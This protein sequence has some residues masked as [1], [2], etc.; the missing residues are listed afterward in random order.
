MSSVAHNM[1]TPRQVERKKRRPSYKSVDSVTPRGTLETQTQPDDNSS[2]TERLHRNEAAPSEGKPEVEGLP[3]EVGHHKTQQ[4]SAPVDTQH[5]SST[6]L[7]AQGRRCTHFGAHP[8]PTLLPTSPPP[9]TEQDC[10]IHEVKEGGV[11]LRIMLRKIK[12]CLQ[13]RNLRL[14]CRVWKFVHTDTA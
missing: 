13:R 8:S 5:G 4:L 14:H 10:G 3:S 11:G 2:C 6:N 9:H 1:K 12:V 7:W